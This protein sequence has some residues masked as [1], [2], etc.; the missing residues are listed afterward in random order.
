M[1]NPPLVAVTATHDTARG[2]LR[3]RVNASYIGAL[4]AAGL[5][6]LIVPPLLN[7]ERA[8]HLLGAVDGLVLT[9]GEDIDPVLYSA[10][11]HPQLGP[12]CAARDRT[13]IALVDAARRTALPTLAICRGMQLLNVALGGTLIQDIPSQWPGA[14]AHDPGRQRSARVH[15][16]TVE[17]GTRTVAALGSEHVQVNSLHHQALDRVA[18]ALRVTGRAAD[19]VIEAVETP[20]DEVWWAIGVQWHPEELVETADEWDRALFAAFAAR[21]AARAAARVAT[22]AGAGALPR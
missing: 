2:V 7:P 18:P 8:E 20:D 15:E 6:P 4:E 9:G 3:V 21:V 12:V 17:A 19:G 16:V 11:P 22:A 13:E 5:V 1:R 10:S 14:A